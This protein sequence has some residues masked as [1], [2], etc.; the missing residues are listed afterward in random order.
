MTDHFSEAEALSSARETFLNVAD[1]L[2][3]E[4]HG[5]IPLPGES[6]IDFRKRLAQ[7]LTPYGSYKGA[8]LAGTDSGLFD[9]VEKQIFDEA[10]RHAQVMPTVPGKLRFIES[11]DRAGRVVAEP[12]SDSDPKVWMNLFSSGAV[13]TGTIKGHNIA[14]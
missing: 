2:G 4:S 6:S 5:A 13:N 1:K 10:T 8:S 7:R 3:L 14:M 11:R 12:S 9:A